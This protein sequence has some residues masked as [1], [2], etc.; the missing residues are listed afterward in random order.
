VYQDMT[1][2][3]AITEFKNKKFGFHESV[4]PN[5]LRLLDSL[6]IPKLKSDLNAN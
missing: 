2:A 3:D 4:F 6:D 1:R 5:I